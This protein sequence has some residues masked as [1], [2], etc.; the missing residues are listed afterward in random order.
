MIGRPINFLISLAIF[1]ATAYLT[2][3]LVK[4]GY[5]FMAILSFLFLVVP[6]VFVVYNK[7][8]SRA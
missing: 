4:Y 5:F 2:V 7:L 3:E 6:A 1:A 8:T